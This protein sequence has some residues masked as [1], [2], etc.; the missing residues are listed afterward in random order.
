MKKDL[1]QG[2]IIKNLTVFS[3]PF[4]LSTLL[5]VLYGLA[6]LFIIGQ[7]N[8]ADVITAVS[9]GSQFMH[10]V[11]VMIVGLA[12]GS[13]VMISHSIGAKDNLLTAKNIG[14]SCTLFGLLS[15]CA[16][17][18]FILLIN[19]L[20]K[21]IAVPP[22]SLNQTKSY[23][24][25]CFTGIP[26]ITG[27]NVVSSIYR[28]IGDSKSP[29]IFVAIACVINIAVDY[30]LIGVYKMGAKGAALGTVIAQ[31][32]SLLLSVLF[33]AK[34]GIGVKLKKDDFIPSLKTVKAIFAVGL[35]IAMQDSFIQISFLV[36]TAI[37]NTRGIQIAAAVGIIEKMIGIMFIVPS[38]M[39]SSIS[40]ISAQNAGAKLNQRAKKTLLYGI[41]ISS[42][43]SVIFIIITEFKAEELTALFTREEKVII[44]GS[45]YLRAYVI[46]CLI[47]GLHFCFSGF[48]TA[49]QKSKLS[50]IHNII[51]VITTRIPLSY[52]ATV[53]WPENLFPMGL[54]APLGSLL[55]V[56][57][58]LIFYAVYFKGEKINKLTA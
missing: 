46:D 38:S 27:Y 51:S 30:L 15:I 1:T 29:M 55:S 39:M 21:I 53:L 35:P 3:I 6:D 9:V 58:C 14:N 24:L 17:I 52:L 28:G 44:Y 8:G 56:I 12:M 57:I 25:I 23:I 19:P 37:A 10:M 16:S 11:T 32:F 49:Y 2:S 20:T 31:G 47:A 34:K 33:I 48:F 54:A 22:E 7:F 42:T 18:L 4:V 45:Q 41:M 26:L 50:F 36:I 13:T 40:A 5:Q 43:I